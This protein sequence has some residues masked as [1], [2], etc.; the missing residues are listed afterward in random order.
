MNEA[1]IRLPALAA[2]LAA[3]FL[4]LLLAF[5][6]AFP[7]ASDAGETLP[8]DVIAA[9]RSPTRV[10]LYSLDPARRRHGTG[11]HDF[12]VVGR[13]TVEGVSARQDIAAKLALQVRAGRDG[14]RCFEPHHGIR[15]VS[16]R[17]IHDPVICYECGHVYIYSSGLRARHVGIAGDPA[18]LDEILTRGKVSV[19]S[20][21]Y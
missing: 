5:L 21:H 1:G 12:R 3:A 9:F 18:Y 15:L 14:A 13:A 6:L 16:G 4:P 11:F 19:V 10:L 17:A 20:H 7:A 2:L 8:P